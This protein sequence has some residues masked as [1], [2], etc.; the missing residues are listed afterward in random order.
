M[1]KK[2][3]CFF[4][5]AEIGTA[6][7]RARERERQ[8]SGANHYPRAPTQLYRSSE[9]IQQTAMIHKLTL[10][11]VG[12]VGGFGV[13][14]IIVSFGYLNSNVNSSDFSQFFVSSIFVSVFID[15]ILN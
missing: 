15:I 6:E 1:G 3:F 11:H 13:K 4:Q 14:Y 5:T 10:R 9:R 8:R 12:H 7:P 2:H